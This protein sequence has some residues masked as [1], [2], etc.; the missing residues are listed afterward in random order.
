MIKSGQNKTSNRPTVIMWQVVRG[1]RDSKGNDHVTAVEVRTSW[2]KAKHLFDVIHLPE[3][4]KKDRKR[5]SYNFVRWYELKVR[6]VASYFPQIDSRLI[7]V[8]NY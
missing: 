7:D 5:A 6:T 2:K 1:W 3:N 4:P 8:R